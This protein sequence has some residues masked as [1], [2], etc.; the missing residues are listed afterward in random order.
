MLTSVDMSVDTARVGAC[1]TASI[2]P[3]SIVIIRVRRG[4]TTRRVL[5]YTERK[6]HGHSQVG[7]EET[8]GRA[9]SGQRHAHL[10]HALHRESVGAQGEATGDGAGRCSRL[11]CPGGCNATPPKAGTG[12]NG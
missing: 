4:R 10:R 11:C 6:S 1:A 2:T 3:A 8:E 5:Q 7:P 9:R 12:S